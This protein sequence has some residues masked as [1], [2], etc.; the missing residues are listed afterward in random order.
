MVT[1][2]EAAKPGDAVLLQASCHNP[3]GADLEPWQWHAL[4]EIMR[5]RALIPF[6]DL[7]YQGFGRGLDE[8]VSELRQVVEHV[9]HALVAVTFSK[10]LGLYRERAGALIIKGNNRKTAALAGSH[11]LRIIRSLY[12]MPPDWGAALTASVLS[13]PEL[14]QSWIDELA[15][16]R[17]R[18]NQ[19][20]VLFA[21]QLR[22]AGGGSHFD[23]ILAQRGMFSLLGISPEA[24]QRLWQLH[25]IY[26]RPE[27]RVNI[28]GLV[29]DI[30]PRVARAIVDE[31]HH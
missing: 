15:Q 26:L 13:T 28:S 8:D 21:T 20:R 22:N 27:G 16:M 19:M 14:R 17:Q 2:L 23:F 7:A 11:A 18:T 25:H 10:N 9:D 30:V 3:T 4:S 29:A 1:T 24:I 6:I 12:C 31:M 5:R